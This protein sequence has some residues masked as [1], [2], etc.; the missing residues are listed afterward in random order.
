MNRDNKLT[1]AIFEF[2]NGKVL[3]IL[4]EGPIKRIENYVHFSGKNPVDPEKDSVEFTINM[5]YVIYFVE[6]PLEED[7]DGTKLG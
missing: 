6:Q 3:N 2:E 1:T 7:K 5:D 4:I